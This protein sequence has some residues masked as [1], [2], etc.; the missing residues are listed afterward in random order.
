MSSGLGE[1]SSQSSIA[2]SPEKRRDASPIGES[3]ADQAFGGLTSLMYSEDLADSVLL[4]ATRNWTLSTKSDCEEDRAVKLAMHF[5]KV[6]KTTQAMVR[7]RIRQIADAELK[8]KME[9]QASLVQIDLSKVERQM[10]GRLDRHSEMVEWM[11]QE[12]IKILKLRK[13]VAQK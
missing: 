1:I 10:Q 8:A 13:A 7:D 9:A 6:Q 4:G 2:S 3:L 12:F 5:K 11:K